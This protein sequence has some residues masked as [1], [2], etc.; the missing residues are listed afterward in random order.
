M[1]FVCLVD[2]CGPCRRSGHI[3]ANLRNLR[4]PRAPWGQIVICHLAF[5]GTALRIGRPADGRFAPPGR[6]GTSA[7]CRS[8]APA[9]LRPHRARALRAHTPFARHF[10]PAARTRAALGSLGHCLHIPKARAGK[11]VYRYQYTNMTG[12]S[13]CRGRRGALWMGAVPPTR[14]G[15]VFCL[16]FGR[17]VDRSL[18]RVHRQRLVLVGALGRLVVGVAAV[19]SAEQIRPGLGRPVL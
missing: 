3:C 13:P 14:D 2:S 7:V 16:P 8:P 12:L 5:S 4:I 6:R 18:R 15:S 9:G 17:M 11:V 1:C 19:D 10:L